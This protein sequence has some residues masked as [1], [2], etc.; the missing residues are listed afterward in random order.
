MR[1]VLL[2]LA[3][4]LI[5]LLFTNSLIAAEKPPEPI[6]VSNIPASNA[7]ELGTKRNAEI[8]FKQAAQKADAAMKKTR[9]EGGDWREAANMLM[10]SSV[11]SR[12]G[13]FQTAI[14]M[15]NQAQ[16]MAEESYKA[17][18]A[19]KKAEAARKAKAAAATKKAAEE[20]AAAARKVTAN[21]NK[22]EQ[23]KTAK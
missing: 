7:M 21:L 10:Q 8:T 15:A 11:T 14:K 22:P 12:S 18:I 9:T 20:K 13:D 4:A 1:Y 3:I 2:T 5:T 16:I 23:A 17:A 19:A 6:S